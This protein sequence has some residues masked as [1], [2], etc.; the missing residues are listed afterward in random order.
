MAEVDWTA[1]TQATNQGLDAGDVAKGVSNA[2][3]T[4]NGGGSFAHVFHSLQPQIGF[5]GWYFSGLS[6]FNPFPTN[7][8]GSIRAALRR[9][10]AGV[11]YAPMIGLIAGTDLDTSNAY[12]IGLS[13]TDPYQIVLRKGIV[14]GGL[15]P[16][17]SDVL[18]ASNESWASNTIYQHLRLDVIVNPQ[19]DVVLNV[20]KNDL[21]VNTVT[22]PNWEAISGMDSFV[23]DSVGALTGTAP[24]IS[25]FRGFF[26]HFNDGEAG[27][28]SLIDHVELEQQ[29]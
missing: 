10:S 27:K 3:S 7:K 9:Y 16:T 25:G 19:G 21:D 2:F 6:S 20:F 28:V 18:R 11:N 13:N 4:P 24:L 8:G 12:L 23:D 15:D 26:G 1:F 14:K 5:A 17:G 22:S 29:N